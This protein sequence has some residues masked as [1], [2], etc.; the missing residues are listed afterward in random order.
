VCASDA[1]AGVLGPQSVGETHEPGRPT[2]RDDDRVHLRSLDEAL[3]QRLPGGRL[4]ERR[5][6]VRLELS[7]LVDPEEPA[8][9]LRVCGLEH[10]GQTDGVD[11][12]PSLCEIPNGGERG[13][14]QAFLG[15]GPTHRELV[16][17]PVRGVRS[18]RRQAEPLGDS[19][20]DRDRAVLRDGQQRVGA[21]AP[22][23]ALDRVDALDVGHLCDVRVGEPGGGGIVVDGDDAVPELTR[24]EDRGTL[25]AS[26]AEQEDCGHGAMLDA[27]S[28]AGS[29]RG[30]TTIPACRSR[31]NAS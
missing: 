23:E 2:A 21:V 13:L 16:R 31:A 10:C 15:E 14:R 7:G 26:R 11:C 18:E 1:E 4:R 19:G 8:L 6:E 5:M 29:R 25:V 3:E 12:R 30:S 24:V 27:P 22:C 17:E 20:D 28:L 9:A